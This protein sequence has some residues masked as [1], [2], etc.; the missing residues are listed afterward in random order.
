MRNIHAE[1]AGTAD[2]LDRKLGDYARGSGHQVLVY[3]DHT[4][5]GVPIE[6]WAVKA[7][8]RWR[9]GRKGIDDGL[10]LFV[11]TDDRRLRIEVR[12]DGFLHH[13]V[14]TMV[15]T[16]VECASQRRAA[17]EL[18]A[19]L[20]ARDRG[21]AGPNAPARGLYLAGVRYADG[22]DSYAEPP[23]F[24]SAVPRSGA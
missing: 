10:I 16:L 14:R 17:E 21:A 18:P 15:G 9:V 19:I 4:T 3:I 23:I 22:Y 7:F 12:A 1:E 11:F 24:L 8:E 5:G 6:D 20:A 13:M 2:D